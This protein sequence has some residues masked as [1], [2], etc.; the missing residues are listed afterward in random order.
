MTELIPPSV[1]R[2][3][4]RH[5]RSL[6]DLEVL[7]LLSST[8]DKHWTAAAVALQL[9]IPGTAAREALENLCRQNLLDVKVG[10]ALSYRYNPGA[11]QLGRAVDELFT[12][13]QDARVAVTAAVADAAR[14]RLRDFA[15]AFRVVDD[16]DKEGNDGG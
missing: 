9:A 5:L 14:Q 8:P 7:M 15:D 10:E 2:F 13:Y 6:M 3:I 12:T 4:A 11:P 16:E 1:L